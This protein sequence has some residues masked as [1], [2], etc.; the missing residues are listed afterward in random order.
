M[1]NFYH[2]EFKILSLE[3][4]CS[5]KRD[6]RVKKNSIF[7]MVIMGCFS[8]LLL[9][10][11]A[12]IIGSVNYLGVACQSFYYAFKGC[13][14]GE[15]MKTKKLVS[16]RCQFHRFVNLVSRLGKDCLS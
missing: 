3:I 1:V 15:I 6:S 10:S 2:I 11:A 14:Y 7:N 12:Q 13:H 16:R 9:A 5:N 8:V 4:K